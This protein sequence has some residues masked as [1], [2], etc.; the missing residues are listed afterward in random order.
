M[1]RVRVPRVGTPPSRRKAM[2]TV[3]RIVLAL[4]ALAAMA[5]AGGAHWRVG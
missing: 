1:M 5:L 2:K 3:R 4:G